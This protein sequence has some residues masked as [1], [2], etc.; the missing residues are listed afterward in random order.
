MQG[1]QKSQMVFNRWKC[2]HA[3]LVCDEKIDHGII[4]CEKTDKID[5]FESLNFRQG[6]RGVRQKK[7]ELEKRK[8]KKLLSD[9]YFTRIRSVCLTRVIEF[10]SSSSFSPPWNASKV[11]KD[12]QFRRIQIKF[13]FLNTVQFL[14]FGISLD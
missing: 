11:T 2:A 13:S 6:R 7:T 5:A 8:R 4:N 3:H 10:L 9:S 14:K 1:T 12:C